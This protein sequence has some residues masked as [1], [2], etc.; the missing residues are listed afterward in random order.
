MFC[1]Y[2]ARIYYLN[3]ITM[4]VP[5]A[6]PVEMHIRYWWVPFVWWRITHPPPICVVICLIHSVWNHQEDEEQMSHDKDAHCA[7]L[8]SFFLLKKTKT[9][10]LTMQIMLFVSS[11]T[12]IETVW[13]TNRL[14]WKAEK[15]W[16]VI[17]N[18]GKFMSKCTRVLTFGC[19]FVATKYSLI[20]DFWQYL[21][22]IGLIVL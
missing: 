1:C 5:C 12:F 10:K 16:L 17:W 18:H 8:K 13:M 2:S 3:W 4:S 11:Y 7:F 15:T 14:E 9:N 6:I 19:H 22:T 20:L 21:D